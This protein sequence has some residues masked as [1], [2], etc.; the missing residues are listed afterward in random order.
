[1]IKLLN[2]LEFKVYNLKILI[3]LFFPPHKKKF[4]FKIKFFNI[5]KKNFEKDTAADDNTAE[6][7]SK[8]FFQK[9]EAEKF[10]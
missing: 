3:L 9:E 2:I 6:S 10:F 7:F 5:Q 8:K 1:M 4:Y